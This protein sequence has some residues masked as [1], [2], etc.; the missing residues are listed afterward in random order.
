[1]RKESGLAVSDRIVLWIAGPSE[2]EEAIRTHADWIAGEVLAREL[3]VGD[4]K[5]PHHA[6][7]SVDI[8]GQPVSIAFER[9]V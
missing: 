7:Q 4:R 8:D 1:M 2:I 6:A 9:T 5:E 3:E